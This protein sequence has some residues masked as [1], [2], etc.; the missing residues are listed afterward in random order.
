MQFKYSIVSYTHLLNGKPTTLGG[1]AVALAKY[2][3]K[4]AYC[5]WQPIP[6]N[7]PTWFY[8]LL[9]IR[10]IFLVLLKHKPSEVYIGMESVNALLGKL[11]GYKKVIYWNMDYSP[12]R[13]LIWNILDMLAIRYCDEVW[14]LKERGVGK[15][16]PIGCWFHEIKRLPFDRIEQYGIVYIGLLQDG[17]GVG[18]MIETLKDMNLWITIIGAGKDEAR[19][20]EMAKGYPNIKF[21]G[22]ISDK[23]AQEIMC[24]NAYG[25]AVYHPDNPTHKTTRPTKPMTYASCGLVTIDEL[26]ID[27]GELEEKREMSIEWAKEHDWNIIFKECLV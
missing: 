24:K 3:G 12:R 13:H 17:Q 8:A 15:V 6:V 22:L 18:M 16:V 19:Y 10:D 7:K 14:T 23:K 21:T 20:K 9:K 11:L 26:P 5:I 27:W 2:L 25:W 4:K 1:P